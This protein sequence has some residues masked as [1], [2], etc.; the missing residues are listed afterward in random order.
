VIERGVILCEGDTLELEHVA[1][2]L[3][4]KEVISGK[5]KTLEDLEREHILRTLEETGGV[6]GGPHGAAARLGINRTTLNSR[7][8]KLGIRRSERRQFSSLSS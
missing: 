1:T 7:M 6:I 3:S 5:A 4:I 8:Q 2:A